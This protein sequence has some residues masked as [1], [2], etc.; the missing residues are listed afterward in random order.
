M[1][2]PEVAYTRLTPHT[3]EAWAELERESGLQVV[4]RAGSLVMGRKG[5]MGEYSVDN[6]AAAMAAQN[7]P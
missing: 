5:T 6:Y 1:E 7:I 4:H 3:Y 2:Y